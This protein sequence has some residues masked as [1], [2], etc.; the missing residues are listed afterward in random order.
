MNG[1]FGTNIDFAFDIWCCIAYN[2]NGVTG[3]GSAW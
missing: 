2:A 3:R 1:G